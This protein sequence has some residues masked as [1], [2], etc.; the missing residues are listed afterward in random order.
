MPGAGPKRK[1]NAFEREVVNRAKELGLD[2]SRSWASD[3]RSRGMAKEVDLVIQGRPLQCKRI[4]QLPQWIGMTENVDAAVL[5]EDHGSS[6]VV[7]RLEDFFQ[8][9]ICQSKYLT[10]SQDGGKTEA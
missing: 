7:L 6:L 10:G 5:R 8:L 2:A 1:G 3:G 4:K 9:L